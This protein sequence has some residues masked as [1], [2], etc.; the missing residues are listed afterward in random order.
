MLLTVYAAQC[1][2][3]YDI[4]TDFQDFTIVNKVFP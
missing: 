2:I 1:Y 4:D 3:S